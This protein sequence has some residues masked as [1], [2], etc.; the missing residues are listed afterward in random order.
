MGSPVE[1]AADGSST[2]AVPT[3]RFIAEGAALLPELVT[4][5]RSIHAEPE[6]GLQ[7]PETQR[8]VLAALDPPDLELRTGTALSSV[9]AVLRGAR[10]GPTVLLRADMDALPLQERRPPYP[11]GRPTAPCTPAATTC[12]RPGSWG[13]PTCC[14]HTATISQ[15]MS[16]SCSNPEKKVSAELR[17][18]W[19]KAYST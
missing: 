13:P 10:P 3:E 6:V 18:C 11:S 17:S 7:L 2:T 14:T 4:L 8:K 5:R 12:T 16:C 19:R 15:A 9:V 1:I